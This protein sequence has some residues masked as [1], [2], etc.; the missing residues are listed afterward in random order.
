MDSST[1]A[2]LPACLS[3]SPPLLRC[4]EAFGVLMW[5]MLMCKSP[6]SDMNP[7]VRGCTIQASTPPGHA[8][9]GWRGGSP[10]CGYDTLVGQGCRSRGRHRRK[11]DSRPRGAILLSPRSIFDWSS[12][13]IACVK[14]APLCAA[15]VFKAH[16][17]SWWGAGTPTRHIR[18]RSYTLARRRF[19]GTCC[20][21]T[22]D[23]CSTRWRRRRTGGLVR[24][25]VLQ[26]ETFRTIS[27]GVA[28]CAFGR[29]AH[30]HPHCDPFIVTPFLL[31]RR[32]AGGRCAVGLLFD[33]HQLSP[34]GVKS[35][36]LCGLAPPRLSS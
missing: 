16:I 35:S 12:I 22:C 6:Y 26:C 28:G 20:A 10:T 30:I 27:Y 24:R 8:A 7:Q 23:R 34:R 11:V 17:Q 9:H 33:R 18:S 32:S 25:G 15:I 3:P 14:A 13:S 36:P 29:Q 21:P 19:L 5:E 31:P 2:P 4:S 1:H